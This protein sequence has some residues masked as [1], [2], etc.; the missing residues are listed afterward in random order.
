MAHQSIPGGIGA[1]SESF[2]RETALEIA[3]AISQPSDAAGIELLDQKAIEELAKQMPHRPLLQFLSSLL[4][5]GL[6]TYIKNIHGEI[7]LLSIGKHQLPLLIV[8]NNYGDSYIGSLYGHYV[9]QG[10]ESE[11][12]IAGIFTKKL[13]KIAL[14]A[15]GA[16]LRW[17]KI[18]KVVYVNHSLFATDLHPV[19]TPQEV[20]AITACLQKKFPDYA[21]VFRSIA[22]KICPEVK[23]SLGTSGYRFIASRQI[24]FTDTKNEAI[25]ETRIVKSD[26]VL[27][28]KQQQHCQ[29]VDHKDITPEEYA[30]L[31]Q[32]Y[33]DS[34]LAYH[35][36]L[37][38]QFT[39]EFVQNLHTSRLLHLKYLTID[40]K[41][42]GVVGFQE[43]EGRFLCSFFGYNKDHP[44]HSKIYR[45]LSTCLLQEA[46]KRQLLFHQ[47]AGA[48]FYKKLRRA[49]GCLDY[50]AY[51]SRHLPKRQRLC[52]KI[53]HLF[54]NGFAKPFMRKY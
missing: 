12:L 29:F 15:L 40:D 23:E 16:I 28:R 51:N 4:K 17:G 22:E 46:K 48:S 1:I 52:W 42:E 2:T 53:L 9:S 8:Q 41:I 5:N 21:I 37:N 18:D 44:D 47:S 30:T 7:A 13:S 33:D 3:A 31:A 6:D 34:I 24:F 50:F 45:L 35:S 43:R 11:S 20:S 36:N 25:F 32:L 10:L 26:L 38:P 49:E 54:V 27:W 19:L 14:M 39:P